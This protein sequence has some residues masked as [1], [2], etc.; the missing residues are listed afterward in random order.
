[1]LT[2]GQQVFHEMRQRGV[3]NGGMTP[4]GGTARLINST[5]GLSHRSFSLSTELWAEHRASGKGPWS[6]H[7]AVGQSGSDRLMGQSDGVGVT[8]PSGILQW[9]TACWSE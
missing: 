5:M 7:Q 2:T 4:I 9:S 1:M 8:A 3:S 6:A